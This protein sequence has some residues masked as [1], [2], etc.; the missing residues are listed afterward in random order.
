MLIVYIIFILSLG[1]AEKMWDL[2]V[3]LREHNYGRKIELITMI[4]GCIILGIGELV[5]TYKHIEFAA[6]QDG[7]EETFLA[8]TMAVCLAGVQL[9]ETFEGMKKYKMAS[10][11][12]V[13]L[14]ISLF[15]LLVGAIKLIGGN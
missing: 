11:K 7:F 8:Y 13:I 4:A 15:C 12:L 1:Y 10:D 6:Q 9:V 5:V 3:E 14:G 2:S